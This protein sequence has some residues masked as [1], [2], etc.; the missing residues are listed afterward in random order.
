MMTNKILQYA[1]VELYVEKWECVNTHV[2]KP[3]LAAGTSNKCKYRKY[4]K[5]FIGFISM[6]RKLSAESRYKNLS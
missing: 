5:Y 2:L 1:N 6:K 3:V 4:R